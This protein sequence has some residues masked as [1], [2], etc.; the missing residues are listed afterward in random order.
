M[1]IGPVNAIRPVPP[2]RPSSPVSGNASDGNTDLTGIFASEFRDQQRDDSYS[3][4]R[5]ASRGLEDEDSEE[6]AADEQP[7]REQQYAPEESSISFFA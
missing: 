4:S 2:I 5:K 1:D 7:A 6:E 3:P